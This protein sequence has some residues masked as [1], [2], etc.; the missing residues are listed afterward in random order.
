MRFKDMPPTQH[1]SSSGEKLAKVI[2]WILALLIVL[3]IALF[4]L[5]TVVYAFSALF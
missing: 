1:R 5:V 3:P 2:L 4:L